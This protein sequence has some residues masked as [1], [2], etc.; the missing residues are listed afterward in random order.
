MLA[1]LKQS[2]RNSEV[3][4]RKVFFLQTTWKS[5]LLSAHCA[6]QKLRGGEEEEGGYLCA[7]VWERGEST[8]MLR[9]R[10]L[11]KLRSLG[12][13]GTCQVPMW[14][15]A[16]YSWAPSNADWNEPQWRCRFAALIAPTWELLPTQVYR[17]EITPAALPADSWSLPW[18]RTS[19]P[20]GF[21]VYWLCFCCI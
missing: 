21:F 4:T 13:A 14:A 5:L 19:L 12:V 3:S 10:E 17:S 20:V 16:M 9:R 6:T 8:G 7:V 11:L 18:G 1:V 2:S 15:R